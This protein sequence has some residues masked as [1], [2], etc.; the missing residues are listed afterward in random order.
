MRRRAAFRFLAWKWPESALRNYR[1]K[2]WATSRLAIVCRGVS[3]RSYFRALS[4]GVRI[5]LGWLAIRRIT[6]WVGGGCRIWNLLFRIR[7]RLGLW[8]VAGRC[9]RPLR[10][11]AQSC[12]ALSSAWRFLSSL[13]YWRARCWN[14]RSS[15]IP[16][17]RVSE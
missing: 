6:W 15:W 16:R 4:L 5:R 1:R 8:S 12:I 10:R 7:I 17:R 13:G 11:C 3:S 14:I 2:S 9:Q